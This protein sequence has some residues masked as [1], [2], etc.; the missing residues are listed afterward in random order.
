[1][2]EANQPIMDAP[3][4]YRIRVHGHATLDWIEAMLGD[5]SMTTDL[6]ESGPCST[7]TVE[8]ADQ[9]TL[10]GFINALYNLGHA[11]ISMEQLMPETPDEPAGAE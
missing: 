11:V 2:E 6:A 8:T 10:L 1:M 3:A 4:T 9:A 7:F 5:V